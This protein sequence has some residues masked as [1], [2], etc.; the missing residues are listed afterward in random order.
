MAWKWKNNYGLASYNNDSKFF[1]L[2][3]SQIIHTE[4]E[5]MTGGKKFFCSFCFCFYDK[6]GRESMWKELKG[7]NI[8]DT[9]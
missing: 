7:L 8:Q 5:I 4:V 9:P 3:S 6:K 1:I 2:L